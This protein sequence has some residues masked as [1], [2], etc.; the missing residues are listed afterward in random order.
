MHA[1]FVDPRVSG[2]MLLT[3]FGW[4][5]LKA[6]FPY[7]AVELKNVMT[8]GD[9]TFLVA[10]ST[11]PYYILAGSVPKNGAKKSKDTLVTFDGDLGVLMKMVSG[12]FTKMKRL[13]PTT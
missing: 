4:D 10:T 11:Y 9:H 7:W 13:R 1:M 3:K 12:D 5:V 6:K 2:S 8:F